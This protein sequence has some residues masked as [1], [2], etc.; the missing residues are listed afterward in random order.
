MDPKWLVCGEGG[1]FV[2][3]LLWSGK[4]EKTEL[5]CHSGST[6]PGSWS[7][8]RH[9]LPGL[10]LWLP[11]HSME[12]DGGRCPCFVWNSSQLSVPEENGDRDRNRTWLIWTPQDWG[13]P[14]TFLAQATMPHGLNCPQAIVQLRFGTHQAEQASLQVTVLHR[15]SWIQGLT[16]NTRSHSLI[17][18]DTQG[19][20]EVSWSHSQL[21]IWLHLF[22]S[23][24]GT[25]TKEMNVG[26][27]C[28]E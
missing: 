24:Q 16:L 23:L 11:S 2:G 26:W 5:W 4:S 21:L 28:L 1:V 15:L 7:V 25:L 20:N 6:S 19:S 17:I 3:V 13:I 14:N 12:D 22:S 27:N 8:H 18:A 9:L 10:L